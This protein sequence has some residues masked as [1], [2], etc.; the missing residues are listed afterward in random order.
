RLERP[1]GQ[2]RGQAVQQGDTRRRRGAGRSQGGHDRRRRRDGRGSRGIRSRRSDAARFNRRRRGSRIPGGQ[3]VCRPR[4]DRRQKA[5]TVSSF[6]V[7]ITTMASVGKMKRGVPE[8]L[9][10]RCP[11][12]KAT[13]FRKEAESRFNVCP[14]CHHHFY[15]PARE[16]IRQL[17]DEDSFEEWFTELRPKDPLAFVDRIGY[18]ERLKAEQIKTGM[19]D[20]AVVGRGYIRGRP[21]FLALPHFSFIPRPMSSLFPHNLP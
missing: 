18:D 13:I 14:K 8:G 1:D 15:L 21:V 9:W 16:R 12:C 3:D 10:I 11:Q 5:L 7:V 2:V 4:S 19:A 17:L 20:A 6:S